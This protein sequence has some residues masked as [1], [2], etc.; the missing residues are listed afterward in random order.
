[1]KL[2]YFRDPKRNF[3]DDLNPWLWD[4][5]LPGLIDDVDDDRFL[6][7]MGTIL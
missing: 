3:G 1:M 7:G 5:L 4:Q 6:I 2:A